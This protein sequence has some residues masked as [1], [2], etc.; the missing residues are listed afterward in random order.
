M[1]RG[2]LPIL[3]MPFSP[4]GELDE[5]GLRKILAFELEGKVD[6]VGINGF[7]TEAYKLTDS[8]RE[9]AVD[10]VA[11]EIAGQVPLIIGLAPGSTEAAI[12]QAKQFAR[13]QPAALMVLPPATMDNGP[14]ALVDHYIH[15]GQ[16]SN[17][18][19]MV[20]QSP[21]IPQYAHCSLSAEQ[22]ADIAHRSNGIQYFKIEGPGAPA[23]MAALHS[24]IAE[25]K[26]GL[27]G[28]GG[29][30]SFPDEL[31]AGASGVIPGVGFNEVFTRSWNA[32]REGQ[33]AEVMRILT[34]HQPL[35][36]A[37]SGRGHEYSVHARKALMKRAGLIGS[38]Y[39]RGP[40]VAFTENDAKQLFA[41]VDRFALRISQK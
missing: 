15:L 38:S 36:D 11:T 31:K 39:V 16:A 14:Q 24:L 28:G 17:T 7:A 25:L 2:I 6:G 41:I 3:F 19:I 9:R 8:E 26:L 5:Q 37:V 20:Q 40:T 12:L 22:L 23:R 34:E 35:V 27:F 32:Y 33:D 13:Y 18:P 30:I 10:I 29:G 21:H 4:S 1:L